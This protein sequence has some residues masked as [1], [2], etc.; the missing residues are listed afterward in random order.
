MNGLKSA[1]WLVYALTI[2]TLWSEMGIF[3]HITLSQYLTLMFTLKMCHIH[4]E[5]NIF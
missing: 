3:L 4:Q 2:H 5:K 1:V